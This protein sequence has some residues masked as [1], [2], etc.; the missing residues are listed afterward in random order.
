MKKLE[1][2]NNQYKNSDKNT[3]E[4]PEINLNKIKIV[5]KPE[6]IVHEIQGFVEKFLGDKQSHLIDKKLKPLKLTMANSKIL[7]S[8]EKKLMQELKKSMTTE[9]EKDLHTLLVKKPLQKITD[10]TNSIQPM[11]EKFG[12]KKLA[13]ILEDELKN[14]KKNKVNNS[15]NILKDNKVTGLASGEKSTK[16]LN[17]KVL[18]ENLKKIKAKNTKVKKQ[19]LKIEKVNSDDLIQ[20]AQYLIVNN[21]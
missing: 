9:V 14:S 1:N 7:V 17:K 13:K 10:T 11:I 5:A 3:K 19:A 20:M 18:I 8:D 6:K 2:V 16:F 21:P 12:I 15:S 4:N